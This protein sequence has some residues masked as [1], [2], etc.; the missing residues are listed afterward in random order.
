MAITVDQ[1]G[2]YL[3]N[4]KIPFQ[5]ANE[6]TIVFGT[7]TKTYRDADGDNFLGLV[8]RLEENG[9]YFKLFAPK[10]FKALG[11][12][13]DVFLR[14]CAM[15]QWLTKLVQFEYDDT[16]GEI[17]PIVEFPV[18][19]GTI[20]EKQ[21]FRCIAGMCLIL[22]KYYPVLKRALEDGVIDF[23]EELVRPSFASILRALAEALP[24]EDR[25]AL[26]QELGANPDRDE[27]GA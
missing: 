12:H 16:D 15:I 2:R 17:R 6:S 21:L 5:K 14:A 9:E 18:E 27:E 22:D 7:R 13:V 11:P 19:D 4:L 8:I 26:A 10:A 20:T 24:P 25:R 3:T 1:I 23:P